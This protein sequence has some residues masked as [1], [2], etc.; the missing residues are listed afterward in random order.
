MNFDKF[1]RKVV[2][3]SMRMQSKLREAHILEDR[4]D[5]G[6]IIRKRTVHMLKNKR[7][8][9]DDMNCRQHVDRPG[10]SVNGKERERVE[11]ESR[12]CFNPICKKKRTIGAIKI[13]AIFQ[14]GRQETPCLRTTKKQR[15]PDL[16][17]K[18]NR[19]MASKK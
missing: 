8:N 2:I 17:Y 19:K 11:Y 5:R 15:T 4:V 16:K 18:S 13:D 10:H 6:D 14:I 12:L 9:V 3:R 7:V 1:V